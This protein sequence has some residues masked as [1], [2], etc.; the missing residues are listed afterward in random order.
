MNQVKDYPPNIEEIRKILKDVPETMVFTY[1]DTIFNPSGNPLDSALEA[2]EEYHMEQQKSSPREWWQRY[3]LDPAFRASQEIPAYQKQYQ[4][5]KKE[6][7]DRNKLHSVLF[8]LGMELSG[9]AYGS[10][11][12][13][14]EAMTAIK[15]SKL[16]K[17][18]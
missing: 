1:G 18:N 16:Y 3:L 7:K 11:M 17:F 13:T 14:Q 12:T 2:H 15:R 5:Y 8:S 4:E 9:P 10:I 6:I